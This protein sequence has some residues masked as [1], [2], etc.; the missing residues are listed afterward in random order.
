[1]SDLRC[2][3]ALELEPHILA[4]LLEAGAALRNAD[5]SWRDEKW[6]ADRNLHITLT[7][8]GSLAEERIEA[9]SEAIGA[10]VM[11]R[12]AFRIR[13]AG[14]R[15]LPSLRRC[16]MVWATFDDAEN[17]PCEALA[18]RIKAVTAEFDQ[19]PDDRR[20]VP[21]VTLVRARR[22]HRLDSDALAAAHSA[23]TCGNPSMSVPS[24]TLFASTLTRQGPIYERLARWELPE[25]DSAAN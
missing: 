16:S 10:A 3:V 22:P 20:F 6:V 25:A 15:A 18:S 4:A 2:F 9:V 12:T 23:L 14:A 24:A 21:H 7:F 1:V 8:M 19:A 5:P 13:I 11:D 17:H